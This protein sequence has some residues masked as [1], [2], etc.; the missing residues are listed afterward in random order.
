MAEMTP[1][2]AVTDQNA[3]WARTFR[4]SATNLAQRR[5]YNEDIAAATHNDEER[6]EVNF[7]ERLMVDKG[8]RDVFF[9]GQ[10]GAR[11]DARLKLDRDKFDWDQEKAEIDKDIR[12]KAERVKMLNERRLFGKEKRDAANAERILQQTTAAEAEAQSLLEFGLIPQTE[13]FASG[14]AAI[15]AKYPMMDPAARAAL[16]TSAKF[17]GDPEDINAELASLTPEERSRATVSKEAGGKWRITV[18]REGTDPK[19]TELKEL[20]SRKFTLERELAEALGKDERSAEAESF[21]NAR[22][23]ALNERISGMRSPSA[24]EASSPKQLDRDTASAFLTEAG[25]DKAKARE[26]ARSRGYSF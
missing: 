17:D 16:A 19:A 9:R 7:Q 10:E 15:F 5:R 8:A 20:E 24:P 23:T 2:Q 6:A 25:G 3:A 22:I 12:L 11:A 13:G 21:L 14:V 4:G 1:A 18:N 26:I